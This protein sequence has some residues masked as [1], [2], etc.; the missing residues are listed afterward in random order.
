MLVEDIRLLGQRQRTLLP[1]EIA[2]PRVPAFPWASS[3]SPSP[4]G[5]CEEHT[6]GRIIK[7][8]P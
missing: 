7:E 2:K 8:E 3:P 1:P 4:T 6:V 5:H